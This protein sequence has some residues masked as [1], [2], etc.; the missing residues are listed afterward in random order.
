MKILHGN[1]DGDECKD[2]FLSLSHAILTS[3]LC[4]FHQVCMIKLMESLVPSQLAVMVPHRGIFTSNVT[5]S[6]THRS[7]LAERNSLAWPC[8]R[9]AHPSFSR[10]LTAFILPS[11]SIST[12][13][14]ISFRYQQ[15]PDY[16]ELLAV[17][18]TE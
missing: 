1:V 7:S 6:I 13:R 14:C 17:F 4:Y 16:Y 9:P 2:S 3:H 8:Q 10:C 18:T 5:T 15:G 12:R 11:C